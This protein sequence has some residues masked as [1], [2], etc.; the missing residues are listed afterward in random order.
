MVHSVRVEV[1]DFLLRFL[2]LLVAF[3][4]P[5]LARSA[6]PS[7]FRAGAAA[8]DISP[9]EYPIIRN[10]G[11]LE[12]QDDR[13][14]DPIFARCLVLSDGQRK[15]AIVIVD[16]CMIPT[17]VCDRV[18]SLAFSRTQIP[19]DRILIAATH[20]H[21][22]PSVMDYC[23]GSRADAKYLDY[24]PGK[25]AEAVERAND[26]MVDAQW[27]WATLDVG[28]FT[29]CRRWI[30]RPDTMLVDPFGQRSARAMMHPGHQNREYVGPA[31]PIDP[32]LSL[33]SIQT[34][35]EEPLALL[36]NFSMHY[37]GG[38]PGISSDYF[39][40]FSRMC[41]QRLAPG[42][43][44]FV[45]M[46]SQ[47]TSGD[48]W[49]GDYSQPAQANRTMEDYTQSLVD[50]LVDAYGRLTYRSDISMSFDE[51]RLTI[52]RRVPDA[53]RLA[54][55]KRQTQLRGENRPSNHP[56][57]YAEQAIYLAEHPTAEVV[58]QVARIGDML[59]AATPNEVFALT[60]LKIKARSPLAATMNIE[61]ANGAE[62]YIPPPEQHALG[63]YTTW[64]ARTAGLAV[65]AEPLIV[66]NLLEML[67][68]V[69]GQPRRTY[70][71]PRGSYA[72]T[73]LR[74]RPYAY[75]RCAEQAGESI[76]DIAGGHHDARYVGNVAYHLPGV[77]SPAFGGGHAS[78]A[79]HLAGGSIDTGVLPLPE[80]Y[81]VELWCWNGLE[82]DVRE[83]TGT[84]W[85][86][87][88][89]CLTLSGTASHSR[90]R[91]TLGSQVG[92][93]PF[94]LR[95]WNHVVLVRRGEIVAVYLNGHSVPEL[96]ERLPLATDEEAP[97]FVGGGGPFGDNAT[98]EGK[99][100]EIAVYDR[101]LSSDE[102]AEHFRAADISP[103]TF[104]VGP[105]PDS[106]P[107]SPSAA[108]ASIH[109][110]P[111]FRVE[112]VAA[113]PLIQDPVAMDWGPDGSLWVAEMAD[114]PL[115]MDGQGKPGGRIRRLE[116][117]D[118]DG[119]YDRSTVFLDGLS[120]PNGVLAWRD[121]VLI[122]AAP[123]ILF[124]QDTDGDGKA[125]HR[126]PLFSGFVDG[127]QQLRVNGLRWG[128]DNWIHCA[129]GAHHSGFGATNQ[130]R[131]E[132]LGQSL[133]L[134][135]RDFR[136]RPDEGLLEPQSGPSQFGRVR[137]E[138][139]NWFGVQNSL[140]LWHY[141]LED[142]YLRRNTEVAAPDPRRLLRPMQPRVFPAKLP[143]KRYHGFDHINHYTSACGPSIYG[144]EL[145]FPRPSEGFDAFTC[146]PFHNLVQHHW[147]H[148][149]GVSFVADR[150]DDQS[151]FDFFASSDRWC[152]PV[153]TRTGPDGALWVVDMYRYMI[154][155]PEF[156]PPEGKAEL[157]PFYRCGD[158]YG[159]IY[160]VI[161]EKQPA[162][163]FHRLDRATTA[164]RVEALAN[165]NVVIRDLAH[166][167]LMDQRDPVGVAGLRTMLRGQAFPLARLHALCVLDGLG[168][169]SPE[170]LLVALD[171][172]E[173]RIRRHALRI[174]ES[175]PH[176]SQKLKARLQTMTSEPNAAVRLQFACS[177]GNW[178]DAWAGECLAELCLS[179]NLDD[180]TAAGI[181]SS[182]TPHYDTT[183]RY[184]AAHGPLHNPLVM[185]AI[186]TMGIEDRDALAGYLQSIIG[187][188][189][190][191]D[192]RQQVA[193]LAV[194]LRAWDDRGQTV[195]GVCAAH[196]DDLT[197]ALT[198]MEKWVE[199]AAIMANDPHESDVTR[200]SAI[201][202]LG[203]FAD[204]AD[205]DRMTL[206]GL[207]GPL[208]PP[209]ARNAAI[210]RLATAGEPEG[211]DAMLEHWPEYTADTR[212]LV[213]DQLFRRESELQR[214][215]DHMETGALH[216]ADLDLFRRDQ[217][218][219]HPN[220]DV[221]K[222]AEALL[223]TTI[224][225]DRQ[226][227][228]DRY[229]A[230]LPKDG[231]RDRGA[232]LFKTN[233]AVCHVAQGEQSTSLGPDLRS[234][235]DRSAESLLIA[236]LD[237]SRAVE[238]KYL[239]YHLSLESGEAFF[240]VVANETANS[241]QLRLVDGQERSV[242][243]SAIESMRSS[244]RSFMP[245]GFEAILDPQQLADVIAY[246]QSLGINDDSAP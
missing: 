29:N 79:I 203:R 60:G 118:D 100:D 63:G 192:V 138:W 69:S 45:A 17:D 82:S 175:I 215:L 134:G 125:D 121:G 219:R 35:K 94:P 83:V 227:V 88:G 230:G 130:I 36:A 72:E 161:S 50:R 120:F 184:V 80:S 95:T 213:F 157:E 142:Q 49:W 96:E 211:V 126:E 54:W 74:A 190:P 99:L 233:C 109:V 124:A 52:P 154:E 221:G 71:E 224:D 15:F 168:A 21:S 191:E 148:E 212:E 91:L 55:A 59:I 75:W 40:L 26:A 149:E 24:L 153:M 51:R 112:L 231:D 23:L 156:L 158:Q 197:R 145:L 33:L 76:A 61:L 8:V 202:L 107:L 58:L 222:R 43:S 97:G 3:M 152:R 201:E 194:G 237:P 81:S 116:D 31:G 196:D 200:A 90:G 1:A 87:G 132:R 217:L 187:K 28:E 172:P 123:E 234:L 34:T 84:L 127:N 110:P 232:A 182:L 93:T 57:V 38:H 12:A 70:V 238:P 89:D 20:T 25:I 205:A 179:A 183:T 242:P 204:R 144:D 199:R 18:K 209:A 39:G 155:H 174:A 193:M 151:V 114:Y 243:R 225:H 150:A 92:T 7:H 170:D 229:H 171:D 214:F 167:L 113:E 44:T 169:A 146:E 235:T 226:S 208:H 101:P 106:T 67:E 6:E 111:G 162:R 128:L 147:A 66:E 27:A 173:H 159:R 239:S 165:P 241:F 108:L 115:G 37:F 122:T 10:G 131:A 185:A 119:R 62:G 86:F 236:I 218:V 141:V 220:P 176:P 14:A 216:A 188:T 177:L 48:L 246:T 223:A 228:I 163:E 136:I 139:G 5:D 85:S 164:Q 160:R 129:S 178:A 206:V 42:S 180:L 181:I 46:M 78:R 56:E 198:A 41:Q 143:E 9:R 11:F 19:K 140:P 73:I 22:A 102:I 133:L 105:Q 13:L 98:W 4:L 244:E 207:L 186:W 65:D 16:S 47:G 240:G 30:T 137:D 166:R 68:D 32:W 64:P 245:D 53:A 117:T 104:G 189:P 135:S 77:D 210:R 2:L 103:A 195:E